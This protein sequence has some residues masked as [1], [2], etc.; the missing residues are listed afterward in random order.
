MFLQQQ[1]PII[2]TIV[3]QPERHMTVMDLFMGSFFLTAL[4]VVVAVVLGGVVAFILVR[5]HKRHPP[6]LDHLPSVSPYSRGSDS[7]SL[8][9]R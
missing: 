8:P 9:P 7:S 2:I 1:D 4:A 3:P 6:E 5:K